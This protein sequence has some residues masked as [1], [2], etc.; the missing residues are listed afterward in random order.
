VPLGPT[1]WIAPILLGTIVFFV[2]EGEKHVMRK[3]DARKA[4][5][6]Q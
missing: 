2:V 5:L 3:L 4:A 6:G 1:G